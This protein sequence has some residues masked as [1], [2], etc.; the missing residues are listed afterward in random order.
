MKSFEFFIPEHVQKNGS[1]YGHVFLTRNGAMPKHYFVRPKDVVYRVEALTKYMS[2]QK[3][4]KGKHL[5]SQASNAT[6]INEEKQNKEIEQIVSYW[7]PNITINWVVDTG[8][9][10]IRSLPQ[11]IAE[12]KGEINW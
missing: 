10:S 8:S 1:L 2:N 12:S 11:F 3:L 4:K 9:Y 6:I 7:N 5:L